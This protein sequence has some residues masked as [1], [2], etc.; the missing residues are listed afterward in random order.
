MEPA[1]GAD[2]FD[3]LN[4]YLQMKVPIG[5]AITL[6]LFV[7]M[8]IPAQYYYYNE[9]YYDSDLLFEFGTSAGAMNC[10]TDLGGKKGIGKRFIKDLNLRNT[11]LCFSAFGMIMYRNVLGIRLQ[12]TVGKVSAYDSILK[13]VGP[14]TFLRYERNLSFRS[15]ITE[16]H[17][18]IEIHPIYFKEWDEPPRFSP[19]VMAGIGYFHF[20]PEAELNG[21]WH[22]LQPLH[23]EGQGFRQVPG[24]KEYNLYEINFPLGVGLKYELSPIISTRLELIYRILNTDYLD[25]VST[26]YTEPNLFFQNLSPQQASLAQQLSDRQSEKI[27]LHITVP[28]QGRGNPKDND[29]FFSIELKIGITFRKKRNT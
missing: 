24:R 21:D 26:S 14:T 19:Y 1:G 6:L 13:D 3:Q 27:P 5:I 7:P 2:I 28:G 15:S 25:D 9:K 29:S 11:K 4:C 16:L 12:G 10:L 18:G 22:A 8:M 17:L 20:N 23:T